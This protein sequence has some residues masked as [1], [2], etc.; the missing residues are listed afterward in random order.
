M[1]VGDVFQLY[2]DIHGLHNKIVERN[3]TA[4]AGIDYKEVI[5]ADARKDVAVFL[6][7]LKVEVKVSDKVEKAIEL[8]KKKNEE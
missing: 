6:K 5:I 2:C 3:G 4:W 7:N 1:K 8:L